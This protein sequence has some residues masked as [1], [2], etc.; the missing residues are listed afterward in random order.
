MDIVFNSVRPAL[1]LQ[2]ELHHCRFRYQEARWASS[3]RRCQLLRDQLAERMAVPVHVTVGED[4]LFGADMT[5]RVDMTAETDLEAETYLTAIFE[6]CMTART[7][8]TAGADMAAEKDI[9]PET[10]ITAKAS[11]D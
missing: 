1:E 6:T 2:R 9:T 3:A 8:M 11:E 5:A 7:G 4:A 10:D